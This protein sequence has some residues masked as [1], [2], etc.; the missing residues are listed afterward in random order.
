MTFAIDSSGA[1]IPIARLRAN[2]VLTV[3][4]TSAQSSVFT[5]IPSNAASHGTVTPDTTTKFIRLASDIACWISI[6]SNPTAAASGT[7]SFYLPAGVV[8]YF[9]VRAGERLAALRGASTNG[10]LSISELEN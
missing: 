1:S 2:Q 3:N 10:S 6:G 7:A 8:E 5:N 4:D 9:Q